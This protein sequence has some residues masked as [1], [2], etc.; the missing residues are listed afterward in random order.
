VLC[1]VE[2]S[3]SL[4]ENGR[5]LGLTA[6]RAG[7]RHVYRAGSF[8]IATGGIFG[9]GVSTLPGRAFETIFRLPLPVPGT[10]E[11]WSSPRLFGRAAHPFA[12]MGVSVDGRLRAVDEGGTVLFDNVFF[13]G[14]TL[15]GYDFASEK[16]GGGVA[17]ATGYAAGGW[18]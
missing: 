5:C 11:L 12:R 7:T 8:I 16:S 2:V 4:V 14:R 15:G 6:E 10:Q 18:A 9:K 17:L 3:G 13:A 1:N